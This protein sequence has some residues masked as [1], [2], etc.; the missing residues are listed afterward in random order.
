MM[1][2]RDETLPP[3]L[4]V[5][6]AYTVLRWGSKTVPVVLHNMTG[7]PIHLR[8]GQKVAQVQASNEVPHPQLKLGTLESLE[9]LENPK[10]TLSVEE[11]QEKLL[12]C[13]DLSG[14]DKWPL[15][16]VECAHELLREYHDVFSLEDNELG[17]TSQVKHSIKVTNDEPFKEQFKHILP[18]LIVGRGKDTCE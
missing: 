5:T 3:R 15:E 7:L 4:V 9:E 8:K 16:K 10:P 2:S 12:D 18:P 14:L 11:C 13:L 6:S 1:D 17:C